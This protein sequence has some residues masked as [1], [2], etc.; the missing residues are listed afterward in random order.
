MANNGLQ[1]EERRI[2]LVG[3]TSYM[4]LYMGALSSIQE[5]VDAC[6]SGN[7][8]TASA[9]W[10]K[11][12]SW[13][14]GSMEGASE[15]GSTEGRLLWA[16]SKQQCAEFGTCS[17]QVHGSSE[18]NDL[19]VLQLFT[20]R[21]A[22][23]TRSCKELQQSA[24]RIS[25]LLPIPLIQAAIATAILIPQSKGDRQRQ[26]LALAFVYSQ[27]ILPLIQDA[28]APAAQTIADAFDLISAGPPMP[29]GLSAVIAAYSH[30][31]SGMGIDCELIGSNG[32]VDTCLGTVKKKSGL[33]AGLVVSFVAMFLSAYLLW[34]CYRKRR[35]SRSKDENNP[36]FVSTDGGELNHVSDVVV[37][38]KLA[39]YDDDDASSI[40][41]EVDLARLGARP[42]TEDEYAL[43]KE[44]M[45][46][47]DAA[48]IQIV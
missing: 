42:L 14:I 8:D 23:V 5:A 20:G 33:I 22:A 41:T 36:V 34:R 27:A 47:N 48:D 31:L 7:G 10:D 38:K 37:T 25:F 3:I 19:I 29:D 32:N 15:A 24:A 16:L 45:M 43:P 46:M 30:A 26:L 11:A 28:N 17:H 35:A 39:S 12:A 2:V 9:A 1:A 13:L 4:I 6:N 44:M 40:A 18:F 21:G